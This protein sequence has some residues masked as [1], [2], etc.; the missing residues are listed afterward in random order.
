M[1]Y[2]SGGLHPPNFPQHK[3]YYV[4]TDAMCA[5]HDWL[6]AVTASYKF[7][8][9]KISENFVEIYI[10]ILNFGKLLKNYIAKLYM[11]K[12]FKKLYRLVG[13]GFIPASPPDPPL[14]ISIIYFT[15]A[16]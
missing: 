1:V 14:I 16:H 11:E 12:L 3:R 9:D 6:S 13:G 7:A 5:E 15:K 10:K 8:F 4:I 2:T